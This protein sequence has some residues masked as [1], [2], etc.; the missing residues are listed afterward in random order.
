MHVVIRYPID[1]YAKQYRCYVTVRLGCN[2]NEHHVDAIYM[3]LFQLFIDRID[4]HINT[5]YIEFNSFTRY[6]GELAEL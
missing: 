4:I 2:G 3:H 6:V 1:Q 5:Y